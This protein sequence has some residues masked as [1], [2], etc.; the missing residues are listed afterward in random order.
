LLSSA[1]ALTFARR[2]ANAT[3]TGRTNKAEKTLDPKLITPILF[4]ALIALAIYR[5]VRRNIGRQPLATTRLAW[6]IGIFGIVGALM[7]ALSLRD[8]HLFGAMAAGI[9]GG[10]ALGWFGLRHTQFEVTPSGSFYTPHTYIGAFVSA[11]FLGRI[12]YRYLVLYS[13]GQAMAQ[14][15]ASPFDA[16]QRSPLTLAI[17]GVLVGYYVCYY[18]GVLRRNR[19]LPAST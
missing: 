3:I 10:A 6:R 9:G 16:Y 11:L 4:G 13:S 1:Q 2:R 14:T 19:D 5:R 18:S 17:F 15:G 8:W 12:A 7:L